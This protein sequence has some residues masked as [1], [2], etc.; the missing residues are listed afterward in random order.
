MRVSKAR[1]VD[2]VCPYAG[3][4]SDLSGRDTVPPPQETLR[5]PGGIRTRIRTIEGHGCGGSHTD[6][7]PI[8]QLNYRRSSGE[9]RQRRADCSTGTG[10]EIRKQ[11]SN[12]HSGLDPNDSLKDLTR[13]YVGENVKF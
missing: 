9:E 6:T 2:L 8:Y 5:A 10:L 3:G 7:P 12:P 4:R 13:I 1:H 11:T